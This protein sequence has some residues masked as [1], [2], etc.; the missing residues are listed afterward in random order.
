MDTEDKITQL[1]REL[2]L[3]K[4]GQIVWGALLTKRSILEEKIIHME[5]EFEKET[6]EFHREGKGDP[7]LLV[8]KREKLEEVKQN[9]VLVDEL[10]DQYEET[11]TEMENRLK[12][13]LSN[14]ILE[15]HPEKRTEYE[16]L[17]HTLYLSSKIEL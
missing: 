12:E 9:R 11:S 6:F 14:A 1:R 8:R 3:T 15:Q 4:E 13:E 2:H 5:L 7:E 17:I 16:N 10:L